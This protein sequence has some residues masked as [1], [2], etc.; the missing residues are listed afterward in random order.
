LLPETVLEAVGPVEIKC[1][2]AKTEYLIF[3]KHYVQNMRTETL[4]ELYAIKPEVRH[5]I[6]SSAEYAVFDTFQSQII[7]TSLGNGYG[8]IRNNRTNKD[9]YMSAFGLGAG[10]GVGVQKHHV[11]V[12]FKDEEIINEMIDKGW[13]FGTSGTAAV[14]LDEDYKAVTGS[15]PFSKR[16]KTY[17]FTDKGIMLGV[18]PR[19]SK[20]WKDK[21]LN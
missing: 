4:R 20:I 1:P 9:T 14:K 13:T 12:I 19:R 2:D 16:M 5:E 18:S 15:T 6:L 8:I 3:T 21:K 10:L 11:I 17:A 7:I